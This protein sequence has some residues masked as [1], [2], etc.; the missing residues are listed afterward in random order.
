MGRRGAPNCSGPW[1]LLGTDG[2]EPL[3]QLPQSNGSEA[4]WVGREAGRGSGTLG[5]LVP[6]FPSL[7]STR[8][9]VVS[10]VAGGSWAQVREVGMD[11]GQGQAQAQI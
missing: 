2:L 10:R 3:S 6:A 1:A 11:F 9:T 7:W 8:P 4:R 5:L